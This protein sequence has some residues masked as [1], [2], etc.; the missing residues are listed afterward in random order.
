MQFRKNDNERN[1]IDTKRQHYNERRQ[2]ADCTTQKEKTH[3]KKFNHNRNQLPTKIKIREKRIK[4][5]ELDPL[6]DLK[7]LV[8]KMTR[9]RSSMRREDIDTAPE[10]S[11][12]VFE[13]LS[14]R[15][16]YWRQ[17]SAAKESR[18]GTC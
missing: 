4:K 9:G 6:L 10:V 12:P 2:P 8:L 17:S 15:W 14:V 13:K 1:P 7:T 18:L 3:Y 16:G 11:K 5:A